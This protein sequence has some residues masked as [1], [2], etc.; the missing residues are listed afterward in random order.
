MGGTVSLL[1]AVEAPALCR[2]LVLFDPVLTGRVTP[3][4]L[5]NSPLYQGATRRRAVYPSRSAAR[6]SYRG[7]GAFKAWPE[8]T[9]ADYVRAGFRTL[10][11]GEV[12]LTCAPAWEASG[13]SAHGHDTLGALARIDRPMDILLAESGS[14]FRPPSPELFEG[15]PIRQVV[16]PG[17]THLLPMEAGDLVRDFLAEALRAAA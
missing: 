1:A 17:T 2:R 10:E 4:D 9:L 6:D 12:T 11:T 15:R 7:R 14:T 13:F 5:A 16:A 8:D 3:E